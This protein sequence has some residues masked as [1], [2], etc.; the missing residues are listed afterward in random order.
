M[1]ISRKR[2]RQLMVS[3]PSRRVGDLR[4]AVH[5]LPVL[6][7]F[8]PLKAGRRQVI[9]CDTIAVDKVSIPSRRVGDL[10]LGAQLCY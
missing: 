6:P 2:L 1:V 7:S 8:H 5:L 10:I 4:E 3:I 9:G